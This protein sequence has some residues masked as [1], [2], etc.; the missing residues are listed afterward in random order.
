MDGMDREKRAVQKYHITMERIKKMHVQMRDNI[1]QLRT[2]NDIFL[3]MWPESFH[4]TVAMYEHMNMVLRH[5]RSSEAHSIWTKTSA[6]TATTTTTR[7]VTKKTS[8]KF[9]IADYY[10]LVISI[11]KL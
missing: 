10:N 2:K 1:F 6:A 9:T 5:T 3:F 11:R 4:F 7:H 8:S